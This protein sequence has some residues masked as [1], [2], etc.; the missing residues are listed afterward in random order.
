[1]ATL[2]EEIQN[3]LHPTP[4]RVG[5]IGRQEL[6]ELIATAENILEAARTEITSKQP[7]GPYDRDKSEAL[8]AMRLMIQ[9]TRGDVNPLIQAVD[10]SIEMT[11][12]H[13]EQLFRRINARPSNISDEQLS[14]AWGSLKALLDS[15]NG[16]AIVARIKEEL[17]KVCRL[18]GND[19]IS[20]Y[21]LRDGEQLITRYLESRRQQL[22]PYY[23]A[24]RDTAPVTDVDFI[25]GAATILLA[26]RL[27]R[28][29]P[30]VRKN[31]VGLLDGLQVLMQSQ[32]ASWDQPAKG[33]SIQSDSSGSVKVNFASIEEFRQFCRKRPF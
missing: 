3:T 32:A 27:E 22:D 11:G 30:N 25:N 6:D 5:S 24:C 8:E 1:M 9:K 29:W 26:R 17:S 28:T 16:S 20:K 23:E 12:Q 10:Q 13:G 19:E 14:R 2:E 4:R 18:D 7:Q 33:L 31:L 21:L 15:L